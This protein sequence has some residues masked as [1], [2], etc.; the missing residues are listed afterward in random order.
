MKIHF[1]AFYGVEYD[2]DL[3]PW[4]APFYLDLRLDSYKLFLHQERGRI[5]KPLV[6]EFRN[7]GFSI[8]CI[9]GPQGNGLLRKIVLASYASGLP[10]DDFLVVADADEFQAGTIPEFHENNFPPSINYREKCGQFDILTGFLLDCFDPLAKLVPCTCNPFKQYHVREEFTK[11]Q[12]K[13]VIPP[14]L[15]KTAWPPTRRSKVLAARA[16]HE[17]SYEGNHCMLDVPASAAI[18]PVQYPVF[19]FAWLESTKRKLAVKTYYS[20]E[21]LKEIFEGKPPEESLEYLKINSGAALN[22][23]AKSI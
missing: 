1:A 15:G 20:R 22:E 16:G 23:K 5:G 12:L 7:Y 13:I 14:F 3:L 10:P 19:H 21:N 11:E 17:V 6:S 8:K 9:D 4:W 18:D 2:M